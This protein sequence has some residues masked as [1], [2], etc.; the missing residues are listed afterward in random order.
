MTEYGLIAWAFVGVVFHIYWWHRITDREWGA[1]AIVFCAV[2]SPMAAGLGPFTFLVYFFF[3]V[4]LVCT[5]G[6]GRSE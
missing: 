2:T 4:V 3:Y 6:V 1:P 5:Y